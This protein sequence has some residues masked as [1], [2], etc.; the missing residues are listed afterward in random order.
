MPR[1]NLQLPGVLEIYLRL[2]YCPKG[3]GKRW[4]SFSYK[5]E[6]WGIELGEIPTQLC[7]VWSPSLVSDYKLPVGAMKFAVIKN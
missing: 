6:E 3:G 7:S 4:N 2:Y 5:G 1:F